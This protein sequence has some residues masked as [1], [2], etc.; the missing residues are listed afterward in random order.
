MPTCTALAS[1]PAFGGVDVGDDGA[2]AAV[3]GRDVRR[4]S[5]PARRPP[6]NTALIVP[7]GAFSVIALAG[8]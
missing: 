8:R 6:E 1:T 2:E 3:A 7:V 5:V 4:S